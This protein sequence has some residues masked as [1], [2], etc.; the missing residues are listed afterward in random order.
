MTE[1]TE[2]LERLASLKDRGVLTQEEFDR[3]KAALLNAPAA[4]PTAP[5]YVAPTGG[6]GKAGWIA[7]AVVVLLIAA[8]AALW[9]TGMLARWGIGGSADTTNSTA[10]NPVTPTATATAEMSG[11]P[12][13]P[14][15]APSPAYI[16]PSVD[17]APSADGSGA[18]QLFGR[19]WASQGNT[20]ANCPD[21]LMFRPDQMAMDW[22]NR[23]PHEKLLD[24]TF[25]AETPN[26]V[27][28]TAQNNPGIRMVA[29]ISGTQMVFDGCNYL[30]TNFEH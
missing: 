22:K 17:A 2:A 18:A 8:G 15:A 7:L 28:V 16:P 19:V 11:T 30:K 12:M 13:A 25:T 21:A 4:V 27:V 26:T 6:S 14:A 29:Q 23:E 5:T 9:A 10:F 20:S 1:M 3:Q 24:V